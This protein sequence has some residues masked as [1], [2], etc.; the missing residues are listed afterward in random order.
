[1][2]VGL[3]VVVTW[4]GLFEVG[5][6]LVV[7]IEVVVTFFPLCNTSSKSWKL[8]SRDSTILSTKVCNLLFNLSSS[9]NMGVGMSSTLNRSSGLGGRTTGGRSCCVILKEGF[10]TGGKLARWSA[11]KVVSG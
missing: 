2:T 5:G 10:L 3:R 11:P 8:P 7:V 9:T 1:M 4:V 6:L